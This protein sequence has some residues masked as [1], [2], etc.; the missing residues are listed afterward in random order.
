MREVI[1]RF[2][3]VEGAESGKFCLWLGFDVFLL[4]YP[5]LKER[6]QSQAKNT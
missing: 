6:H 5:T 3:V 1:R 2:V 4:M